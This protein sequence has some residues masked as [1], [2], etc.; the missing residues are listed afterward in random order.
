MNPNFIFKVSSFLLFFIISGCHHHE[1]TDT[2]NHDDYSYVIRDTINRLDSLS[3]INRVQNDSLSLI[4]AKIAVSLAKANKLDAELI[5]SYYEIG[6]AFSTRY[7]DSSFFYYTLARKL[8]DRIKF[9]K[10][11]PI[12]L[13]NLANVYIGAF[14]FKDALTLLDSCIH[15]ASETLNFPVLSSAYNSLGQ[16]Y[17]EISDSVM[18]KKMFNLALEIGLKHKLSKQIGNALANLS[19]FEK[20]IYKT[21][22]LQKD[23]INFLQQEP[24]TDEEISSLLI[25]IGTEQT[26]PDSGIYYFKLA[27]FNAK[28]GNLPLNEIAA[29]NN[30]AYSFLDKGDYVNASACLADNAIPRAKKINNLDWLATLYDSYSDVLAKQG[31]LS[32]AFAFLKKSI[33]KRSEYNT[34]KKEEQ[35]RLLSA[36]LDIKNKEL[37]IQEKELE[38]KSK[39]TQNQIL[40]LIL[41]LSLLIIVLIAFL[42]IT[43]RQKTILRIKKQQITSARRIIEIEEYE[44]S[45]IGFELHD[46]IGYL[47]RVLDG[48]I[49][50]LQSVDDQVKETINEKLKE[51]ADRIK[52]ISNRINLMKD[53]QST[54]AE[55]IADIINDMKSLTGIDIQYFVPDH[56][57]V[58]S[59]E[60][61][62][63]ICRITQELLTNANKYAHDSTIKIDL[64]VSE[65]VLLFLYKDNGPGFNVNAVSQK[66][67]GI[68]SINERIT[69]LGGKVIFFSS[70]GKGTRWD[71]TIPFKE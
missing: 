49:K 2:T 36:I 64:V 63:H 54:L 59:R 12:I 4:Y 55:L 14:N 23:A 62:L 66:G 44:K 22:V 50:S 11:K 24:G 57:P 45:R 26:E 17:L 51:L 33:Q 3:F 56:L 13:Y 41:I 37:T 1:K 34:I 6:N 67:I 43:F 53:D 38:L 9:S 30:L 42:F 69:L 27:L 16:I 8:A 71:I 58:L 35:T 29:F 60:I 10:E 39:S 20:S 28:N 25:N 31:K 15:F 19:I 61:T 46:N 32:E 5:K 52:G 7:K 65:N 48:F 70:P 68:R 18:S 40:R 21:L 47:V